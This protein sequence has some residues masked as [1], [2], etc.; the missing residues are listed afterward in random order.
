MRE[1]GGEAGKGVVEQGVGWEDLPNGGWNLE[2]LIKTL[3]PN[4][5]GA[6]IKPSIE[7]VRGPGLCV[8]PLFHLATFSPFSV[9]PITDLGGHPRHAASMLWGAAGWWRG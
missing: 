2:A 8:L 4:T 5:L 9:H 1:G 3:S 6:E 7:R